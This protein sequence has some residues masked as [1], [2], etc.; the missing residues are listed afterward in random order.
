[1]TF[2][3]ASSPQRRLLEA[4]TRRSLQDK[5]SINNNRSIARHSTSST[6][7]L[8]LYWSSSSV[9]SVSSSSSSSFKSQRFSTQVQ[10]EKQ[11][12]FLTGTSSLYAEQLYEQY[13]V[14]PTSVHESWQKYFQ[15]IDGGVAFDVT[16][17]NRP[18]SIPGKRALAAT[19]VRVLL[20]YL[21]LLMICTC[22]T[23]VWVVAFAEDGDY[24]TYVYYISLECEDRINLSH[25]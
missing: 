7:A 22:I 16:E 9:S 11:E 24:E 14:D 23:V 12:T 20:Y 13:L 19:V 6:K 17:Y 18:T 10:Q 3:V 21:S 1:M 15:N 2:P 25:C 8:S 5:I 4:L